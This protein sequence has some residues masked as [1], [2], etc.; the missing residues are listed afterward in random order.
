MFAMKKNLANLGNE[1]SKKV[2]TPNMPQEATKNVKTRT[3][4]TRGILN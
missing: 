3:M 4:R 2:S 1:V